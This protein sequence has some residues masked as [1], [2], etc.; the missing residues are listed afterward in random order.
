MSQDATGSR[1]RG[2]SR[3]RGQQQGTA[4]H[5]Q[6]GQQ[7]DRPPGDLNP[8]ELS[9]WRWLADLNLDVKYQLSY[10]QLFQIYNITLSYIER[11]GGPRASGEVSP[12]DLSIR[13]DLQAEIF[14]VI[15]L[16][17]D[18]S[19][20]RSWDSAQGGDSALVPVKP[21][22]ADMTNHGRA[23]LEGVKARVIVPFK[24]P[25]PEPVEPANT[26]DPGDDRK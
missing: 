25:T 23:Y 14:A 19:I 16:P 24:I 12:A 4:E 17:I 2:P 9:R 18:K 11:F 5:G 26:D 3:I 20:L 6:H 1:S 13:L 21:N 10:S 15:G 7:K 8:P 22:A